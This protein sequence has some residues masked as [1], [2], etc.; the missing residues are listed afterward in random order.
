MLFGQD[1]DFTKLTLDLLFDDDFSAK[2]FG[3]VQWLD[4]NSG[5]TLMKNSE[6]GHGKVRSLK[7]K[8]DY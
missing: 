8:Q 6:E 1:K 2:S 7:M 3:P 5:F 4:D